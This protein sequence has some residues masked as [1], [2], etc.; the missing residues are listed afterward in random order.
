M[1]AD[2]PLPASMHST[3]LKRGRSSL[4]A[5]PKAPEPADEQSESEEDAKDSS[6]ESEPNAGYES[7]DVD[8]DTS[9]TSLT[10][11]RRNHCLSLFG[12]V[13]SG[14]KDTST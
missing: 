5:Q 9:E 8:S 4:A 13:A 2:M 6:E 10:S 12:D 3:P 1:P 14:I 11:F 7:S